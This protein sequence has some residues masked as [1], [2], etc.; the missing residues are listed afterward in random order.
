VAEAQRAE[1]IVNRHH[2]DVAALGEPATVVHELATSAEAER[3]AVNP[4]EHRPA[5]VAPS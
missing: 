1:T 5:R 3:A 2:D 4:E